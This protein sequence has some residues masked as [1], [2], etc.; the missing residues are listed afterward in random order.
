M[1]V[2][3]VS[4]A[5]K[6]VELKQIPPPLIIGERINTQGSRKAKQLV[7]TDDL[8]GL[9]DLGRM[10]VEDGAHCLDVCV[11]TTERSDERSFMLNLVK[12]LSLEIDAPLVIDSTDPDV[13]EAAVT[14]IPGRPIINSINLEGDG[15]RFEKLAPLMA[16]YGLPAI[17][18]C[19]GPKGM[20]KTPQEKLE[21]AELLYETGKKYGLK[22]EQF[23]FDVLT[24]TLATGE[25]EFLDAGKNT[26]EGIRLVKERFPNSFTTL[27]LSNISFGLTP[28]ARKIL[29]S[30]FLYHAVKVGL[31][32]AIVNAKEI[33]PYGELDEKEKKLAEDLIFNAHPNAL[34]DLISYFEKAGTQETSTSKK[35]DVDPSWAPGKRANFRI[36][37]RLKDGIQND[38]VCAIADKLGK[39]EI[40]KD[41]DGILSLDAPQE[42]THNG[43]IRTLNED[44][45][46]AMKEVGDK[47]GAGEL[48]LPFVLKSA[49]CMKAAVG[50]LE[51]YLVKEEGTSKGKLV[52]G[53]VY[54]D[55]H[56]I[57]KNLV[58]TI[59]QNNGYTVYDLG[60]QVP[61]Q[62]F[63]EKID[64]VNPDAIGLSALLVSTSKQ[65]KFFVEH[66]RKNKMNI[67]ILCGGA[68]INSNYIN[69][70]A[71]EDG[72]YDPGV[73]YCNTMFEGLKTMDI[74]ISDEKPKLLS[75]WKQ[76]LENWKDKST[77]SIDPSTLPKSQIK[78]VEPPTPK[79]IGEPIR[80]KLD[81]IKMDEVWSMI[82]KRSLFKLSW[83]L[84]GKAG[85]E[86]ESDHEQL[87]TEWKIRIIREKL[88][89]PEIV[90]GYFRCHNKDGKLLVENPSGENVEFDFP[91][92]TKPEHLCLTDYFGAD[93]VVAFQSVTVGNKVAEI[94]EQW[95]NEDKYTDAYYL[96][97]LAVEVA[98]ALAEWVNQKIKSELNLEKGGLRYS[99]GFP[100]CPDVLQHHL[101][102]KLLDPEKSGMTLTESGQIIPEQS[103]AAIVVHHP[104]AQYFVL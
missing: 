76:N 92:S 1:T 73:F 95:N 18:L 90:Y 35:V 51:K 36:V 10:Q 86:S 83:G 41:N 15:S 24:F 99:W 33:I 94:I 74:L 48:I 5:L 64:E 62:K 93:D 42:I 40:I 44:L 9:V 77:A 46:P 17:A 104:N 85:S 26:L 27:G 58:K 23:I 75:E 54:G 60:K 7:L 84:R 52:L 103:T 63:L 87:L 4:S 97:G 37:N 45:L 61:L 31:D 32:T 14:Q 82:D 16:K 22:I 68:A 49:E 11:A 43:A 19:I 38:V 13:I 57:G 70:I 81:Q 6:A 72:I 101:V 12:R 28:Y 25:D 34:S 55:V 66:A 3:R 69:R 79:V 88:F 100:S 89:E 20:A 65:M 59:F 102:W 21:T 8:D 39:N 30:V 91:R 98:E 71:K 78:P 56:D 47:F 67:P 96:H 50:E 2:P 29:N 53:T 80:L